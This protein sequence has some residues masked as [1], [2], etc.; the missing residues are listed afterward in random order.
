[1]CQVSNVCGVDS[2]GCQMYQYSNCLTEAVQATMPRTRLYTSNYAQACVE[3]LS[4][5]YGNNNN[6]IS[7]QQIGNLNQTCGLVFL[8]TGNPGDSFD[9]TL[10]IAPKVSFALPR[11]PQAT[12]AFARHRCPLSKANPALRRGRSAPTICTARIKQPDGYALRRSL[13]ASRA[14]TTAASC[15]TTASA[16][17]ASRGAGR[18]LRC[19]Q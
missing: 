2:T 19:V 12:R 13:P 11:I 7:Y 14:A 10:R 8:G 1:M 9:L 15:R 16:G 5:A 3:A 4:A 6:Q 18:A 17:S